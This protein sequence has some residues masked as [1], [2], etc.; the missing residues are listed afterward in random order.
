MVAQRGVGV[1]ARPTEK[2]R[3]EKRRPAPRPS[4]AS[5]RKARLS[6]KEKHALDTLP[7]ATLNGFD[8]SPTSMEIAASISKAA[9]VASR[10]TYEEKDAME[11]DPQYAAPYGLAAGCYIYARAAGW[12]SPSDP[13][14]AESVRLARTLC[15]SKRVAEAS[16]MAGRHS[17]T[18]ARWS[19]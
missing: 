7:G 8:I 12:M 18:R 6:F 17:R 4:S 19:S 16:S 9:G 5:T 2:P 1:T 15:F 13:A 11:I 10:V 14:L 3:M